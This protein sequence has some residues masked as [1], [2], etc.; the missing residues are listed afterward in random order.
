MRVILCAVGIVVL[1]VGSVHAE[2]NEGPWPSDPELAKV[3]KEMKAEEKTCKEIKNIMREMQCYEKVRLK[4]RSKGRLRG[5]QEYV[6]SHYVDLSTPELQKILQE[7]QEFHDQAR[8]R[9]D[10]KFNR[11]PGELSEEGIA[12]EILYVQTELEKRGFR[13]HKDNLKFYKGLQNKQ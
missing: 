7:L 13:K 1:M 6:D 10:A 12:S 11:Q 2:L 8:S 4:F 9:N 3:E 5:T